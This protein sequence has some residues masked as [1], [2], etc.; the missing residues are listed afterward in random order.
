MPNHHPVPQSKKT[1]EEKGKQNINI[2]E[3]QLALSSH[4]INATPSKRMIKPK[5]EATF[6]TNQNISGNQTTSRSI[7]QS[8]HLPCT[9]HLQ[10]L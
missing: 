9:T 7:S 6:Y 4:P 8:H 5:G 1:E 2:M 10:E 3:A